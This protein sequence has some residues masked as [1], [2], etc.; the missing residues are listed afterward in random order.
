M[1]P[2]VLQ[3]KVHSLKADVY[4][5]AITL[6][7]I[8]TGVIPYSD[9]SRNVA[10]AHTVLDMSYNEQDLCAA[11]CSEN[12]RPALPEA[13][14][15]GLCELISECWH[16]DPNS[17]PSMTE[18]QRKLEALATTALGISVAEIEPLWRSPPEAPAEEVVGDVQPPDVN[19]IRWP[20]YESDTYIPS[21]SSGLFRTCG[22][23]GP[24]KMEDRH[25]M[26]FPLCETAPD[27]HLMGVFDGHRGQEAS[28]LTSLVLRDLLLRNLSHASGRLE[29]GGVLD[30][31]DVDEALIKSFLDADV[32]F[33]GQQE[34]LY[35]TGGRRGEA[36]KY[37]GC[38]AAAGLV[39][40]NK[41]FVAN[42]G[43]CRTMIC[44]KG[45]GIPLSEDHT[46]DLERERQRVV[47]AGG[48]VK[49]FNRSWRV[50]PAGLQVTRAIGDFDCKGT[51][52]V[53]ATPEICRRT[54][55]PEDEFVVM[56]CD[57]VWDVMS[58]QEVV[59]MIY[60]TV[61]EPSMCAKRLGVEAM[62]RGS[63]DNITV[64]VCFLRPVS[65]VERIY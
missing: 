6:C 51:H 41:L 50:E 28:H 40:G 59:E 16:P 62:N 25:L 15:D 61:K 33:K 14:P 19:S 17:R 42:A 27:V 4:S 58:E 36:R 12:L 57:G 21:V 63:G 52:G 35:T 32:L 37:P 5:F 47:E 53:V 54:L 56:A 49:L 2:E 39:C 8:A 55:T 29:N 20:A 64:I 46:A 26:C 38:T 10:L 45:E 65:T 3:R 9:R 43:D 24:D 30:D 23:R 48:Q 13:A 31:A 1:P 22:A 11:I 18:V 34:R 44:S 60:T 7:E